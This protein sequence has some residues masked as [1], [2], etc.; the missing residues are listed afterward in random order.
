[1]A[2]TVR[3]SPEVVV[4]VTMSAIWKSQKMSTL[5]TMIVSA[6]MMASGSTRVPARVRTRVAMTRAAPK[7]T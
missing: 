1:M 6:S 7:P 4:S 5:T 3:V 2:H